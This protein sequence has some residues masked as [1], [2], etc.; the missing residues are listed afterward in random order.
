M[1]V[2]EYEDFSTTDVQITETIVDDKPA[3]E[4]H[5]MDYDGNYVMVGYI[6]KKV[7]KEYTAMIQKY[8]LTSA[9]A[10]IV[11]GRL[12]LKLLSILHFHE[13]FSIKFFIVSNSFFFSSFNL[14]IFL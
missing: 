6:P 8:N 5:L 1:E 3:Y 9:S 10:S 12:N 14:S 11:G 4:I 2:F 7:I 13:F